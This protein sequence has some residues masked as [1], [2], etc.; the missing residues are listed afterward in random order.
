LKNKTVQLTATLAEK[1]SVLSAINGQKEKLGEE[2]KIKNN[3]LTSLKENEKKL[4]TSLE[5]QLRQRLKLDQS[6]EKV[7]RLEMDAITKRNAIAPKSEKK[8]VP[9]VKFSD[10]GTDLFQN[11]FLEQI[12]STDLS[13]TFHVFFT[14]MEKT[15]HTILQLHYTNHPKTNH[16]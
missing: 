8:S 15:N 6:I 1:E 2:L 5:D 4:A 16:H 3:M 11:L 12:C 10:F 14:I 7:I 9:R 13:H